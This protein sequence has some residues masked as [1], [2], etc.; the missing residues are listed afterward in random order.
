MLFA[1]VIDPDI[2][3]ISL[4]FVVPSA[5]ARSVHEKKQESSL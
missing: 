4:I 1:E 3:L 5:C 2:L